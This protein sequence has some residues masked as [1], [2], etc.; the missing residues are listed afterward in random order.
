MLNELLSNSEDRFRA[1]IENAS[2]GI[3]MLSFIDSKAVMSYVSP[4]TFRILGYF[5]E[6]M[7][8]VDPVV[9]T[10]PEDM[11][12]IGPRLLSLL[13]TP[14]K[15]IQMQ[16]RMRH[17]NG[18]YRW[19]E[20]SVGNFL[21]N[22]DLNAL[23]FNYR[24]I[25]DRKESEDLLKK[26]KEEAEKANKAKTD[27][28][29]GMSHELRTPL[30][31]II[32]FTELIEAG[33]LSD[34]QR[35]LIGYVSDSA[36]HLLSLINDILSFSRIEYEKLVYNITVL[37]LST[38]IQKLSNQLGLLADLY[39]VRIHFKTQEN[40]CILGDE[41]GLNQILLNLVSNAIKYNRKDGS[42]KI[43]SRLLKDK[44]RIMVTDS[45]MGIPLEKRK[46]IFLP[47]EH[48]GIGKR[49]NEGTGLGL[50]I[51]KHIAQAMNGSMGYRTI[52]KFGSVF[53][54]ELP[55]VNSNSIK[56]KKE[57]VPINKNPE[58]SCVYE[59]IKGCVLYIEDNPLNAGLM[60][61]IFKK[62]LPGVEFIVAE[63]AEL[64]LQIA[65]EK[66]LDLILMDIHLPGMSGLEA[67]SK[68]H[69]ASDTA[70]IPVIAVSADV[71]SNTKEA[72]LRIG[73]AGYLTKPYKV[74][75]L[76]DH[77]ICYL[78]KS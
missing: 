43:S 36:N 59:N 70:N 32:G 49:F 31:A 35:T 50:T 39:R 61:R 11:Q 29:A 14:G 75:D 63:N 19:I 8:G 52:Y 62:N 40:L 54:V 7:I 68:L 48:V 17:K 15:T 1:L 24:D 55:F 18:E 2:D 45:G 22:P 5:P 28:L 71:T 66:T 34:D 76:L 33:S 67:A 64:G 37:S 9:W 58:S 65:H 56:D 47:F 53:W 16:Y 74:S 73:M 6:E 72:G 13:E 3:A 10:H 44:I 4:S 20:S 38:V 60:A 78:R 27:F 57:V 41:K 12:I 51:A 77:T 25:T 26:T 42:V 30:N 69:E 46:K 23:V 21:N